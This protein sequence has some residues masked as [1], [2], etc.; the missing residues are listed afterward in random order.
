[1]TIEISDEST[2]FAKDVVGLRQA[3]T[4]DYI[5]TIHL[6]DILNILNQYNKQLFTTI[7]IAM[8]SLNANECSSIH[9]TQ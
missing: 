6:Y 3:K 2:I 9:D 4:T 5:D 1:M 7:V 8:H